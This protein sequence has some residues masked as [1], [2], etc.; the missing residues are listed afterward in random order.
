MDAA[1]LVELAAMLAS[2]GSIL[3]GAEGRISPTS[4]YQYWTA[5]RCRQDRWTRSLQRFT[6]KIE[7]S[8]RPPS[9]KDMEWIV[10]RGQLEEIITGDMLARVWGALAYGIDYFRGN[11]ELAPLARSILAGHGEV[12]C[13]ALRLLVH[14]FAT[15]ESENKRLNRLRRRSERWTDLLVGYLIDQCDVSELAVNPQR[16]REFAQD[17]SGTKSAAFK[18]D[19]WAVLRASLRAAFQSPMRGP[20]PNADL[21]AKISTAI[22]ACFPPDTF[23]SLGFVNSLWNIR[24]NNTTED[25]QNMI[26]QLLDLDAIDPQIS[27]WPRCDTIQFRPCDGPR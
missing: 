6:Q 7:S 13:R 22:L 16:A 20:S 27:T 12:Q 3:V 11:S 18:L 17:L 26:D 2:H 9:T 14:P 23:D 19:T 25:V 10:L 21:N 15:P 5:S 1:K 24:L 8:P 4:M